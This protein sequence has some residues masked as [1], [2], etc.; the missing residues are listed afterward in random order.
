M[1]INKHAIIL[2]ALITSAVSL[3]VLS[4]YIEEPEE[5][6]YNPIQTSEPVSAYNNN[7]TYKSNKS[8]QISIKES[9]KPIPKPTEKIVKETT[10]NRNIIKQLNQLKRLKL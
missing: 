3:H 2:P 6:V 10:K 9:I 4:Y 5:I 8:N 7:A 1:N